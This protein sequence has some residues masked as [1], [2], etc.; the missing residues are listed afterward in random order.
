MMLNLWSALY[1]LDMNPFGAGTGGFLSC[2][3]FTLHSHSFQTDSTKL[4]S[5][6][7]NMRRKFK[8]KNPSLDENNHWMPKMEFLR[9]FKG[10][11]RFSWKCWSFV[12]LRSF[13]VISIRENLFC[14]AW[15]V[16][17]VRLLLFVLHSQFPHFK[18]IC[19]PVTFF[20]NGLLCENFRFTKNTW[21]HFFHKKY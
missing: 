17:K 15:V 18:C 5:F 6:Q 9:H 21:K 1:A 11:C 2:R 16:H 3:N 10:N 14:F 19:F 4:S 8:K 13:Q 20:S 7:L 12:F